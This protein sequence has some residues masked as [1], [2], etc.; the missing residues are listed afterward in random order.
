MNKKIIKLSLIVIVVATVMLP[1]QIVLSSNSVAIRPTNLATAANHTSVVTIN[2]TGPCDDGKPPHNFV[3][4]IVTYKNACYEDISE[5]VN[6][7]SDKSCAASGVSWLIC[8]LINLIKEAIDGIEKFILGILYNDPIV[9]TGDGIIFNLWSSIRNLANSLL[10]LVFLLM[11]IGNAVS[12]GVDSYTVKRT[13]PRLIVA[14]ILIQFSFALCSLLIDFTNVMAVGIIELGT[15]T[16]HGNSA[17][18][19]SG[20]ATVIGIS[21]IAIAVPVLLA[22]LASGAG[23][24]IIAVAFIAAMGTLFTLGLRELMILMLVIGSPLG[25]LAW[26]LP[27]TESLF[28][29]WLKNLT[30]MLMM[31]PLIAALFVVAEIGS[32]IAFSDGGSVSPVLGF[33]LIVAPL[34][35]VPFTFK[36]AGGLMSAGAGAIG[37]FAAGKAANLKSSQGVKDFRDRRKEQ[38]FAK[39]VAEGRGFGQRSRRSFAKLGAFGAYGTTAGRAG[40]TANQRYK[41]SVNRQGAAAGAAISG[42]NQEALQAAGTRLEGYDFTAPRSA[43]NIQRYGS[44]YIDQVEKSRA[45]SAA[46][47]ETITDAYG[48]YGWEIDKV[49]HGESSDVLGANGS[50]IEMKTAAVSEMVGR[51]DWGETKTSATGASYTT[52]IRGLQAAGVSQSTIVAGIGTK[53]GEVIA[54]A[55]DILKG[56]SGEG[57]WGK[58]TADQIV[59]LDATSVKLMSDYYLTATTS[60]GTKA[61]IKSEVDKMAN[62]SKLRQNLS[63]VAKAA[64][65]AIKPGF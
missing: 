14:A 23:F 15:Q 42:R 21:A 40:R 50:N 53:T 16:M 63:P 45:D 36:W 11:I 18:G 33:M 46:K 37:G 17:P 62:D 41:Q 48:L 34:F 19:L 6:E 1:F 3:F 5:K 25:I 59:A 31:F 9:T 54:M 8:P 39:S 7:Q 12:I 65:N 51:K 64:L 44:R 4:G 55:P 49:A 61:N 13:L 20:G 2:S 57:A 58:I 60:A 27:N 56:G 30:K 29:S 10:V 38:N 35:A 43:A 32:S 28:K 26:V 47:G 52:G 22:S 24:V